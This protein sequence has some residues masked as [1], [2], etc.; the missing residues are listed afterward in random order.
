MTGLVL[1]SLLLWVTLCWCILEH[2]VF[3]KNVY[4]LCFGWI[5]S[6]TAL[7]YMFR[8]LGFKVMG[9]RK[10]VWSWAFCVTCWL[11]T[12]QKLCSYWGEGV[13]DIFTTAVIAV[14]CTRYCHLIS[15]SKMKKLF[16]FQPYKTQ[17]Y[18]LLLGMFVHRPQRV[19]TACMPVRACTCTHTHT[20]YIIRVKKN[21]R[22]S[23]CV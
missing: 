23:N 13:G 5:V 22:L 21:P 1:T 18:T 6:Q 7:L 15:S 2:N 9:F 17:F 11:A 10:V 8:A 19:E 14:F 12:L 20:V 16:K 3:C 4:E